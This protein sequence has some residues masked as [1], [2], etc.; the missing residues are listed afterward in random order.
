[1]KTFPKTGAHIVVPWHADS[2]LQRRTWEYLSMMGKFGARN[3]WRHARQ[4]FNQ[5]RLYLDHCWESTSAVM[6]VSLFNFGRGYW[7]P[8]RLSVCN[9]QRV[10]ATRGLSAEKK[11]FGTHIEF[12]GKLYPGTLSNTVQYIIS[13]SKSAYNQLINCRLWNVSRLPNISGGGMSEHRVFSH[14]K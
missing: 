2:G 14:C 4:K 6:A 8:K 13:I 12:S 7:D 9:A 5:K 1:M 11:K 3:R 10:S